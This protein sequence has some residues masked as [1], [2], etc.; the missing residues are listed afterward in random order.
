M[1]LNTKK[2]VDNYQKN[3]LYRIDESEVIIFTEEHQDSTEI[4]KLIIDLR[5]NEYGIFAHEFRNQYTSREGVKTA[6]VFTAIVADDDKTVSTLIFDVKRNISAFS[7]DLLKNNA[8]ITCIKEVRDFIK[9]L[10]DEK[11]CVDSL[12]VL[13]EDYRVIERYGIVTSSF[14]CK[15]FEQVADKYEEIFKTQ[16]INNELL[17]PL[18]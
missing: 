3:V 6:D 18:T 12:L 9:Q 2:F 10:H 8:I 13:L 1:N 7:D 11:I 5:E 17:L 14:D 15:K 4:V 16:P